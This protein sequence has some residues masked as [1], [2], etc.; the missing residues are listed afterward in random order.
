MTKGS[1]RI[2]PSYSDDTFD[3]AKTVYTV[4]TVSASHIARPLRMPYITCLRIINQ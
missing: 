3:Y 4:L 1:L 2:R